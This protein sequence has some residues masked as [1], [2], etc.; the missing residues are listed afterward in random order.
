MIRA[1]HVLHFPSTHAA[2]APYILNCTNFSRGCLQF[3]HFVTL[4][5][6]FQNL[7]N[8]LPIIFSTFSLVV[9]FNDNLKVH[10]AVSPY[11]HS[12]YKL[13]LCWSYFH[14]KIVFCRNL[15]LRYGTRTS[16]WRPKIRVESSQLWHKCHRICWMLNLAGAKFLT[17]IVENYENL[18]WQCRSRGRIEVTAELLRSPLQHTN[19]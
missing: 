13:F 18:G 11:F 4:T 9:F 5:F 17:Y 10:S 8:S 3:S 19:S 7:S 12:D 14:C 16:C 1:L 6:F 2:M 15:S